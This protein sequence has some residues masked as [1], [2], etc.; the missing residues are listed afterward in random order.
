LST[1]G[2]SLVGK[3]AEGATL[4]ALVVV[5]PRALGALEYG[6]F[7]TALAL[8][9]ILSASL[10]MGGPALLSRFVPATPD[11]ERLHVARGLAGRLARVRI[12]QIGVV[13]ALAVAV[14]VAAPGQ[15]PPT[16]AA[17]VAVAIA[18]DA[19][20][21]LAF[22]ILLGLGRTT[23]WSFRWPLQNAVLCTTCIPLYEAMG[24]T[25]AVAAI[26]VSSG[27]SLAVG[28]FLAA[29]ELH[30]VR[31]TS[32]LPRGALRFG[33][34]QAGS[35]FFVQLYQRGPVIAVIVLSGTA[36]DAGFTAL[37]SGVALALTYVVAQAFFVELPRL[38]AEMQQAPLAV[39]ASVR[40]LARIATAAL[41]PVSIVA[42]VLV[43][44]VLPYVLGSEFEGAVPSFGPALAILP[45]AGLTSAATQ[46][47]A[48][49]L[50]PGARLA[51]NGAGAIAFAVTALVAIPP[52]GS[53]GGTL[54]LF[55]ATSVAVAASA[56]LLP[57]AF[58]RPLL[59]ASFAGSAV[60]LLI[61]SLGGS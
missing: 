49:R 6:R 41:V 10:N 5:V 14:S 13:V 48:L 32:R 8:V 47:A 57:G 16:L 50:S 22:Q 37:A 12:A 38:A 45:L 29:R 61:S 36:S 20:A 52:W 2:I 30:G 33:L 9:T 51:S 44:P 58:G 59:G 53:V 25:G 1:V 39:E 24:T 11:G 34:I 18:L 4:V 7:A 56:V 26:V 31:P 40:Q 54:A 42:V 60:V 35:G 43:G 3:A 27:V 28:G 46:V 23:L 19:T 15:V 55:A 17:L 21:T